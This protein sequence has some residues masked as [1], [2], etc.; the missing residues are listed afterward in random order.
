VPS[1][2]DVDLF[3]LVRVE[4]PTDF[5]DDGFRE[6]RGVRARAALVQ[7]PEPAF[8]PPWRSHRWMLERETK[9]VCHVPD[10]AGSLPAHAA[11][12]GGE[13][14]KAATAWR[15]GGGQRRARRTKAS[16]KGGASL[17]DGGRRMEKSVER[18]FQ[19]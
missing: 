11:H 14:G 15:V 3:V 17:R 12:H 10:E 6:A 13:Q 19:R 16:A 1:D 18:N 4:E 5:G 2:P 9:A 8:R 7:V